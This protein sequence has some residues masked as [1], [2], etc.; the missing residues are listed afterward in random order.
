[1]IDLQG[2]QS[3]KSMGLFLGTPKDKDKSAYSV[4]DNM[5][6]S[7]DNIDNLLKLFD[8][9]EIDE[10]SIDD[11]MLIPFVIYVLKNKGLKKQVTTKYSDSILNLLGL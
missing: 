10:S 6:T 3:V 9:Y 4:Y 11:Y 8:E 2:I 5:W 1:M 7:L